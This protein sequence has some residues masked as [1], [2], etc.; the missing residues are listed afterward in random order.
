[1]AKKKYAARSGCP[2]VFFVDVFGD[3]WSLLILR[4]VLFW[5]RKHYSE[6]LQAG[7][8]IATNILADRLDKLEQLGLLKKAPDQQNLRQYLYSPT[9][10]ALDLI[11]FF[12]EMFCWSG[13]YDQQTAIPPQLLERYLEDRAAVEAEIRA[14]F[15]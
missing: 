13:K 12:I 5:Q 4:D 14:Q 3:K 6:F 10:K 8:G 1:M 2:V 7:E 11:P 9:E 15:A